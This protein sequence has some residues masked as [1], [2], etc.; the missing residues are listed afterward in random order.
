MK[1]LIQ[2]ASSAADIPGIESMPNDLEI[3]YVPKGESLKSELS[4]TDIVLA[5]DF[6]SREIQDCWDKATDLKWISWCGA[7]VDTAVFDELRQS[8]V[9]LTNGQGIFDRAMSESVLAYMLMVVKDIR[10]SLDHQSNKVWQYRMNRM[11]RGGRVLIVGV[12]SIGRDF[13]RLLNANGLHCSGAGR[14]ARSGD[15]DFK[16]IFASD[17]LTE[18]ISDFDW[19]ISIMPA[20][21]DTIGLFDE[22]LFCAMNASAHFM[23]LGRGS[24]VIEKD[25]IAALE[26]EEIAGALLD[27]FEN[28][29]LP[30]SD[31][32]WQTKNLF[33]TPHNSG[34]YA[35]FENAMV[36][37]FKNNYERFISGR[38]LV[39]V[40]DK[41]LGFVRS[42]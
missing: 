16:E 22:K 24:A 41:Q 31:P 14:T 9:V 13:A 11:L 12:G 38:P 27:V 33:I 35:E 17:N 36:V 6:K 15:S 29:P 32:L 26:N 21:A 25:L 34:E 5:W 42:S 2:G 4:G 39:N 40:V 10:T 30:E 23:N 3:V 37:L 7:G 28:E 20:T 8:D 18:V 1:L 19:V